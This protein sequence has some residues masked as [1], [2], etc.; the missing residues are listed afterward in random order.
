MALSFP[1]KAKT[2]RYSLHPCNTR[3]PP[4][5]RTDGIGV[6]GR[7]LCPRANAVELAMRYYV[8]Y[9]MVSNLLPR[10][11]GPKVHMR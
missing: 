11:A 10:H 8:W 4:I 9:G 7:D 1:T 2:H 3:A 6:S 5:V